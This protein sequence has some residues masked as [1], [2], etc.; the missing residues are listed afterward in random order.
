MLSSSLVLC[1]KAGPMAPNSPHPAPIS[2]QDYLLL[3][4]SSRIPILSQSSGIIISALPEGRYNAPNNH[5][6]TSN[7]ISLSLPSFLH[8]LSLPPAPYLSWGECFLRW[9]PSSFLKFLLKVMLYT[10]YIIGD[11]TPKCR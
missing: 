2:P 9:F 1:P 4:N 10:S 7:P 6:H 3:L 8:N 5:N 11:V